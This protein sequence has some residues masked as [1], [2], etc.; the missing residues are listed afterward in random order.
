MKTKYALLVAPGKFEIREKE[1]TLGNDQVLVKVAACG[2]C[3]SEL[4]DWLGLEGMTYPRALGH[5]GAG[6]IVE[7][8]KKVTGFQIGDA[9]ACAKL[10]ELA[11]SLKSFF[12]NIG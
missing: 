11:D 9:V 5:E 4:P 2:I 7:V 8:G 6:V 1:L 12:G 3:N 10:G